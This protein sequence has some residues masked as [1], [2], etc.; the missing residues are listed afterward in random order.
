MLT[1][2][3]SHWLAIAICL[4]YT[5]IATGTAYYFASSATH[6]NQAAFLKVAEELKTAKGTLEKSNTEAAKAKEALDKEKGLNADLKKMLAEAEQER[7]GLRNALETMTLTAAKAAKPQAV[8]TKAPPVV[9]ST[10]CL[11]KNVAAEKDIKNQLQALQAFQADVY[12]RDSELRER[13]KQL[14]EALSKLAEEKRKLE[15]ERAEYRWPH[16]GNQSIK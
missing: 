16:N 11:E 7:E 1:F 9:A 3:R 2:L 13:Q 6:E 8:K 4:V 15:R 14:N 10:A 12:K 5:L